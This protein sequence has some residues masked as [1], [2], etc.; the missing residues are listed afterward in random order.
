MLSFL[1]IFEEN[2]FRDRAKGQGARRKSFAP[3]KGGFIHVQSF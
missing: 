2:A 1:H 3:F